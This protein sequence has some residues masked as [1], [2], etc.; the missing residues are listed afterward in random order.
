MCRLIVFNKA[1]NDHPD[2]DLDWTKFKRGDVIDVLEDGVEAGKAV[3]NDPLF[4]IIEM[5]GTPAAEMRA[6]TMGDPIEEG[7]SEHPRLR[8][9]R[10]DL[11]AIGDKPTKADVLA[12]RRT[13]T[14][15]PKSRTLGRG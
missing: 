4:H 9:N 6:L 7:D 1:N 11:D 2:P 15:Q 14:R 5:P 10:L 8:A 3:E 12:H 13:I